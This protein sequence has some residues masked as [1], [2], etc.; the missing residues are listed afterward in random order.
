M[1]RASSYPCAGENP[2]GQL[3][4]MLVNKGL[5]R[6]DLFRVRGKSGGLGLAHAGRR[7]RRSFWLLLRFDGLG[8]LDLGFWRPDIGISQEFL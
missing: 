6:R 3:L 5:T 8:L 4:L 2:G 7:I 1:G